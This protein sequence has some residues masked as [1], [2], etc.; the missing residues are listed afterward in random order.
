MSDSV[1]A[2]FIA[3]FSSVMG[4]YFAN[5]R[6]SAVT[7]EKI[8]NLEG[9]VEMHNNY[10]LELKELKTEIKNIKERINRNV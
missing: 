9:K 2:A 7:Q 5:L 6:Q 10:G 4:S 8:S 1:L 3:A